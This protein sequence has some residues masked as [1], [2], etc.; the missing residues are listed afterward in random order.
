MHSNRGAKRNRAESHDRVAQIVRLP[1]GCPKSG[2][3]PDSEM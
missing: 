2:R 3:T 1:D